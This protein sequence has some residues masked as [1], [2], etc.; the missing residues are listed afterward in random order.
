[1]DS[2]SKSSV[3]QI[4]GGNG[5]VFVADYLTGYI[6][7]KLG[8]TGPKQAVVATIVKALGGAGVMYLGDYTERK[9]KDAGQVIIGAGSGPIMTIA[10][11]WYKALYGMDVGTSGMMRGA[12]GARAKMAA[13]R[14]RT[15][16]APM[17]G[18][19]APSANGLS[20]G[21]Y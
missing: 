14:A 3:E 21:V 4:I 8:L 6:N 5:G 7:G 15:I 13:P 20:L 11:D 19:Q 1:M 16:R 2:F 10:N 12:G 18:S 9:N 17:G